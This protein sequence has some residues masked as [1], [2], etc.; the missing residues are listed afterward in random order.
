MIVQ[1]Q[2]L[3]GTI[4]GGSSLLR[5][6]NGVNYYLSMRS[7]NENWLLYKMAEMPD[8]FED[9]NIKW[10]TNTY[11]C[12]SKCCETL[13]YCHKEMYVDN[14]RKI[15]MDLLDKLRD[16]GMAIWYLESGSKTGRGR[17]NAYINTTK[18]GA[19]GTEIIHRY[20]NEVDMPCNV[21][22]DGDRLKVLFTIS[23]TETL[24]SVI[25]PCVPE[26]MANR[27]R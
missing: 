19:D 16:I 20:F 5:P 6:P 26:F 7:Q 8:L 9:L 27:L 4:L 2:V 1:D 25:G 23:G 10:Y 13:T 11:R 18:F 24:F 15:T 21:N 22:H 3:I 14:N 17:K 12:N